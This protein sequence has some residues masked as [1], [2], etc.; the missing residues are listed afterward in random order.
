MEFVVDLNKVEDVK[1]FVRNAEL[2]DV[3]IIVSNKNRAFAVDGA[4]LMGMFSLNLSDPVL[5]RIEDKNIAEQFKKDV[6]GLIV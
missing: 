2:Y 1:K 6:E 4:S 5:V 3:D